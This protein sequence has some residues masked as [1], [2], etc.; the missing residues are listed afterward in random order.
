MVNGVTQQPVDGLSLVST[1]E[2]RSAPA[3]RRTQ[4]FNV[5]GN[6]AIYHDGWMASAFRGRAPWDVRKPLTSSTLT[7]TWQLYDLDKDF[8]QSRDVAAEQPAK[9]AEMQALFW[10]EA[11]RNQVLPLIDNA[12][13]A[14]LPQL[15]TQRQRVVLFAGSRGIPEM[16]SPAVMMR[17]HTVTANLEL[18][19]KSKGGVVVAYG[20]VAGGWALHVDD[21]RRPVYAYN[22]ADIKTYRIVGDRPLSTDAARIEV[23]LDYDKPMSGGAATAVMKVN[24]REA[25][26]IRIE[27]TVPYL[28]SIHETL[29]V[30]IDLGGSVTTGYAPE[31]DFDGSIRDVVIEVR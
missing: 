3:P 22:Y 15:L 4:Y 18:P 6:R 17:S 7:D 24:G 1:F 11:G 14:G 12:Q 5:Y 2:D 26:R 13:T 20:G 19:R 29:D 27:K 8:S 30:G 28:F 16:Q 23:S 9:L 21:S 10:H 31:S 25:G